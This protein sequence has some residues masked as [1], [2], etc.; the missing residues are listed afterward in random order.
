MT[1]STTGSTPEV[2]LSLMT[3]SLKIPIL[4]GRLGSKRKM[5]NQRLRKHIVGME[6]THTLARIKL[7]RSKL[8]QQFAEL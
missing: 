7:S 1:G 6:I 5:G 2:S 3:S 4:R 8:N